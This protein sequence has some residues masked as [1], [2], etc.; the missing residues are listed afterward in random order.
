[1]ENLDIYYQ[2]YLAQSPNGHD[3]KKDDD[4]DNQDKNDKPGEKED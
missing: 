4:E 3:D 1:M 2:R